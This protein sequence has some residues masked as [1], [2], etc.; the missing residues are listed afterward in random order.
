MSTCFP[1]VWMDARI[2]FASKIVD[3]DHFSIFF[4]ELQIDGSKHGLFQMKK[5][6]SIPMTSFFFQLGWSSSVT[7]QIF[8]L[9]WFFSPGLFVTRQK[10]RG[11]GR[12]RRF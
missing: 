1:E 6:W 4:I 11:N 2:F 5:F 8:F 3:R 10:I 7:H 12:G 9:K